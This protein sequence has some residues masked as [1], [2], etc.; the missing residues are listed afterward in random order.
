MQ[1]TADRRS[2]Q[3]LV[4][5]LPSLSILLERLARAAHDAG[6][7]IVG[8]DDRQPGLFHQQAVDVAQQRAA[9]GQHHAFL[10][11]VRA[12]LGRRLLE[13]GL[14]RADD[15]VE[16]LGQ[17]LQD[18][19]AGNGEAAR[20]ALGQVAALDLLLPAPRCPGKPSRSPS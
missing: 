9:A 4:K 13:R 19:V 12:E 15:A 1:A 17:R 8:H 20:D 5:M 16:R 11:D 14:D 18:F 3:S 7:R 6:Q 10:G 2:P